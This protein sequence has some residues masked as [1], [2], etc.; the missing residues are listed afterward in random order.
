LGKVNSPADAYFVIHIRPVYLRVGLLRSENS[1]DHLQQF[2][3]VQRLLQKSRRSLAE[4]FGLDI[5]T[6]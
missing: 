5:G 4:A 3:R 6:A 1:L 2:R